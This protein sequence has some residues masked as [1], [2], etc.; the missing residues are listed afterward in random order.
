LII[1][2]LSGVVKQIAHFFQWLAFPSQHQ[3]T[4]A[5]QQERGRFVG[6]LFE[7]EDGAFLVGVEA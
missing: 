2:D 6:Y 5:E 4:E 1:S 3:S 7:V